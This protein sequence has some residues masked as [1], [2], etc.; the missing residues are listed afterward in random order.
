MLAVSLSNFPLSVF[1]N[2]TNPKAVKYRIGICTNISNS[3]ILLSAGYA[4]LEESARGF[5]VPAQ[6][7]EAFQKN[8]GL[9][10]TSGIQIEAC[11]S[12]LPGELKCVGPEIQH[13]AIL[14]FAE[15]AFRR[16]E[17]TGIK[18]IVFGSGGSRKI[19]DGFS[20]SEA[21][22]QFVDLCGKMA[23]LAKKYNVVIS[24]EPLN[25]K[26]CNFI[27]SVTEGGEIVKKVNHPNF[28]LLADIYHML[29]ENEDPESLVI[30]GKYL[31][32]IHIAEKE[33]RSAPGT[34]G[35]DFTAYFK[36]LK[37]AGYTGR[38]SLECSWSNLETQA[39]TALSAIRKQ[40]NE[41]LT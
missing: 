26:E 18:T 21:E 9:M 32:H 29:M 10:K 34:H 11:N 15:T 27:N 2:D 39:P 1:G 20:K 40:L 30:Y 41:S 5:L 8:L 14:Q 6:P 3:A 25:S 17:L 4:Y 13:E 33:G 38:I 7:E 16:A 37:K 12:F 22:K 28:R 36:A 23:V 35:E 19:P 24:L 31:Y